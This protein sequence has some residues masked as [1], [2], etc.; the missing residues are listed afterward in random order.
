MSFDKVF[1]PSL[2]FRT[3]E[4]KAR[5]FGD[6]NKGI[7][8][9][10]ELGKIPTQIATPQTTN[11]ETPKPADAESSAKAEADRMKRIRQLSGGKTILTTETLANSSGQRTL[12]GA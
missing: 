8:N 4:G 3:P 10:F 6:V 9:P 5:K 12:L 1:D 11:I 2:I 7:F